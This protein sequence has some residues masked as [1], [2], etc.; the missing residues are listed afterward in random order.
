MVLIPFPVWEVL[1]GFCIRHFWVER[2]C[3]PFLSPIKTLFS[4]A[5]NKTFYGRN[6][7]LFVISKSAFPDMPFQ[8]RLMFAP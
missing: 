1:L 5:C 3:L 4:A 8:P 6:L 7:Q 2:D